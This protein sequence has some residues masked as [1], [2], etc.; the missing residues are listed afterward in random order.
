LYRI[1]PARLRDRVLLKWATAPPGASAIQWRMLLA[2]AENWQQP[3]FPLSGRDVMAAGVPEGPRVGKLLAAL[4]DWWVE[5]D[6]APDEGAL[7]GR[8]AAAIAAE[9]A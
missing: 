5:K 1:G 6:F 8:M 3:R 9:R 4:E 2:M 7:R